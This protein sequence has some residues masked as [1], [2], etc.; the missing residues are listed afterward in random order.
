M[1]PDRLVAVLGTGT[2]VGKTWVSAAV[3]SRLHAAG[4][5][6]AA[7]KPVQSFGPC[8]VETDAGVL[9]L[10][11][12]EAPEQ[13]TPRH[14][15]YAM[16]M[17]PPM[18]AAFLGLPLPRLDDLVAELAWPDGIE[19]GVVETVGGPR[20]PIA[21][22]ADSAGLAAAIEPDLSVLVTHAGLGAINATRLSAPVCPQPL[23]VFLNH[24]DGGDLHDRNRRWLE[25][26]GLDV[27]VDVAALARCL[28]A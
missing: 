4:V 10:A 12:G 1:R 21:D 7:R 2:E 20:S 6:V 13:V 24:F 11:T 23:V 25:A 14:R 19:V 18:A 26:E 22:Q 15:W 3:L 16:A 8:D 27:V 9:A 28:R 5:P 17:A